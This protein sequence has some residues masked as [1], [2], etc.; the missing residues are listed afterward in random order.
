[1][2]NTLT[3][4]QANDNLEIGVYSYMTTSTAAVKRK[5]T[6]RRT[7][8]TNTRPVSKLQQELA[9]IKKEESERAIR[10]AVPEQ[11]VQE[12]YNKVA[13]AERGVG[14]SLLA[15]CDALVE[16]YNTLSVRQWQDFTKAK[17]ISDATYNKIQHIAGCRAFRNEQYSP[18][19]PFDRWTT[20]YQLSK[21]DKVE[22]I[23]AKE[24]KA[25]G[26]IHPFMTGKEVQKLLPSGTHAK[27]EK[28]DTPL[29]ELTKDLVM[30]AP[31]DKKAI[32]TINRSMATTNKLINKM[33]PKTAEATRQAVARVVFN[34]E[35]ASD[36]E[37]KDL[38]SFKGGNKVEILGL[39]EDQ[40]KQ[41]EILLFRDLHTLNV[42]DR[43]VRVT[44]TKRTA[45]G[46]N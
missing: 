9:T 11:K 13:E 19:L 35:V 45:K 25:G 38:A 34:S 17:R 33:V 16:A 5:S 6:T 4:A 32:D 29:T 8:S 31:E 28:E 27:A 7:F 3:L 37:I 20:M 15:Y 10:T 24:A 43:S 42:K 18:F 44:V 40:N 14:K 30:I 1:V 41:F 12:I 36:K 26:K 23:I 39:T 22:T 21:T 2:D 46:I